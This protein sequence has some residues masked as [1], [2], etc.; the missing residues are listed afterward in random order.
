M[1][2]KI[3]YKILLAQEQKSFFAEIKRMPKFTTKST[4]NQAIKLE[5]WIKLHKTIINGHLQNLTTYA[6]NFWLQSIGQSDLISKKKPARMTNKARPGTKPVRRT[7]NKPKLSER[8]N[9][10]TFPDG[11]EFKKVSPAYTKKNFRTQM[12]YGLDPIKGIEG[13]IETVE[14][15][16][17]WQN[18]TNIFGKEY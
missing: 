11:F 9:I 17:Y 13:L 12:I 1:A 3:N 18:A 10:V 14:D 2:K 8:K 5:D 4:V 6:Y 15:F 16:K 7:T